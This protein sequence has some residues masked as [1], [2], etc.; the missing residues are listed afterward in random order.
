M[1]EKTMQMDPT[2]PLGRRRF[3]TLRGEYGR[4][5][6]DLEMP[7]DLPAAAL[8]PDLIKALNWPTAEGGQPLCYQL[9]TESGKVL[10]DTDTLMDAGVENS[11]VLWITLAEVGNEADS[12]PPPVKDYGSLGP[13]EGPVRGFAPV[14]A[15][16][17]SPKDRRGTLAPPRSIQLPINEPSLI[18]A[19]GLIF[20]LGEPPIIIGRASL[21][22][23]P[24]ID[25]TEIDAEVVSS[26]RH[27]E[28]LFEEE[29]HILLPKP[30]TNGTLI[31]G[32]EITVGE[33]HILK[34]G[35][36][37]QF[38]FEGV[39]LTYWSGKQGDLPASFFR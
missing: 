28:I 1:P 36:V 34:D 37:I 38:G 29:L 3:V 10:A 35:D 8:L 12:T 17:P 26:R 39:E 13:D 14:A 11:D 23:R 33:K 25:L 27:A 9:R 30:T 20:V 2:H 16:N 15:T 6:V 31:N 7:G 24:D 5:E 32:V 22:H 4:D 19:D 18:S 21:G